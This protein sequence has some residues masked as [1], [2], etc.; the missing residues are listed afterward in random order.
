MIYACLEL[1]VF[2]ENSSCFSVVMA[3]YP[4]L[5]VVYVLLQL[6]FIFKNSQV[7]DVFPKIIDPKVTAVE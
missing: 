3:I 1:G 5:F 6:Y 7:T 2:V 4:A